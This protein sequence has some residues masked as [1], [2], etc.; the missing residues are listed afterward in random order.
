VADFQTTFDDNSITREEWSWVE[1]LIRDVAREEKSDVFAQRLFQWDLAVRQFRK[2]EQ[3][4]VVLGSPTEMDLH[5]HAL[6]LH[7]LL[8]IGRALVIGSKDFTADELAKLQVRHDEI[9]AYVEELEQSLREWH[10]GFTDGELKRV[11]EAVLG[12]PA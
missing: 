2:I 1:D 8:T 11:R 6:C 7:G 3:K 10:H 4:R 12:G 9:A 5:F